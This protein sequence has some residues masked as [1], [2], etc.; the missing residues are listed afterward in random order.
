MFVLPVFRIDCIG[1]AL[2]LNNQIGLQTA[3]GEKVYRCPLQVVPFKTRPL[4]GDIIFWYPTGTFNI[5]GL[6]PFALLL[7]HNNASFVD[8]FSI[9]S[10]LVYYSQVD[11][12][13]K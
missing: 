3:A 7:K 11:D 1:V 5:G 6:I 12:I 2:L 8:S 13:E 9:Y 10:K 4:R